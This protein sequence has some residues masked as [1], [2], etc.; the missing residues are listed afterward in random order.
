MILLADTFNAFFAHFK[1]SNLICNLAKTCESLVPNSDLVISQE[2]VTSLL[3]EVNVRKAAGPDWILWTHSLVLCCTPQ[4][5]V[6]YTFSD[7]CR[8]WANTKVEN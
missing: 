4:W 8:F 3:K 2:T 1:R 5:F 7:E 6:H